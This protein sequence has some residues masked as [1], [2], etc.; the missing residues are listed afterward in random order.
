[1][2]AITIKDAYVDLGNFQLRSIDLDIP[3]GCVMGCIGRNGAG[4]TTLMNTIMNLQDRER[5]TIEFFGSTLEEQREQILNDV[6]Y[7]PS[8]CPFTLGVKVKKLAS[9]TKTMFQNFDQELFD[10]LCKHSEISCSSKLSHLSLGELKLVQLY[11]LLARKPKVLILD[12]PMANLDP[13][14]RT[15][16]LELLHTFMI[17]EDHT[18]FISSHILSDLEKLADYITILHNGVVLLSE[19]V[20]ILADRYQIIYFDEDQRDHLPSK[21]LLYMKKEREG[22]SALCDRSENR[23]DLRSRPAD[24][25]DILYY[26]SG[27]VQH[28]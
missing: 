1:M 8:E 28:A 4:K 12:E 2:N 7:L 13:V 16:I 11:L 10:Q 22:Y 25:E 5:G 18:I 24:L 3:M 15:E 21:D 6:A 14:T 26:L 23:G 19:Q 9:L 20:D 27:G 17:E